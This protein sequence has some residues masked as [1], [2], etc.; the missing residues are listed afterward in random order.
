MSSTNGS[1]NDAES[2]ASDA[3]ITVHE[4]ADDSWKTESN[5][6]NVGWTSERNVSVPN[7]VE[8]SVLASSI[9][10]QPPLEKGVHECEWFSNAASYVKNACNDNMD[11]EALILPN[12]S[13]MGSLAG[14]VGLLTAIKTV[15]LSNNKIASTLSSKVQYLTLLQFLHLNGN[16]LSG[17]LPSELGKLE[18]L[19]TL[20]LDR[21]KLTSTIPSKLGFLHGNLN[22]LYLSDNLLTGSLPKQLG[23]LTELRGLWA[24]RNGGGL[25]GII[26]EGFNKLTLLEALSIAENILSGTLP[27]FIFNNLTK[28]EWLQFNGNIFSGSLPTEVGELDRLT[29]LDV[30]FNML[31]TTSTSN[32]IPTQM[33]LLADLQMLLLGYNEFSGSVPSELLQLKNLTDLSLAG[34]AQ[35]ERA[36]SEGTCNLL[37]DGSLLYFT[38]HQDIC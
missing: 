7:T 22:W 27:S 23:A 25:T 18:R 26:P 19:S 38:F 3:T 30:E 32:T 29:F 21:N 13:L 16:V 6:S 20:Q 33:G 9:H 10:I 17:P 37:R 28:L 8:H 36:I 11:Y 34:N 5:V 24:N 1:G 35:L 12:N 4:G 2:N 31:S 14:E 15:D